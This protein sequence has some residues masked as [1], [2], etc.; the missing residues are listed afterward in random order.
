MDFMRNELM[1]Q[2][3]PANVMEWARRRKKSGR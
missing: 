2:R 1:H 3:A